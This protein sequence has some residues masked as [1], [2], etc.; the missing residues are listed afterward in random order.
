MIIRPVAPEEYNGDL[1]QVYRQ[2][3]GEA[4]EHAY[5]DDDYTAKVDYAFERGQCLGMVVEDNDEPIAFGVVETITTKKGKY[6]NL[7]TLAGERSDE[8]L[9]DYIYHCELVAR[10]E[11]LK[12]LMLGGR[13][14]WSRKLRPRGF[15]ETAVI[16]TKELPE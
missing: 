15:K 2:L 1:W 7:W 8:W 4:L 6:L 3:V 12:G 9:D 5:R 14:G 13:T 16:M 11:G 10:R